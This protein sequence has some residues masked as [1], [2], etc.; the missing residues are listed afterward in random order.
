MVTVSAKDVGTDQETVRRQVM[1]IRDRK[2]VPE[3]RDPVLRVARCLCTDVFPR[4]ALRTEIRK[5]SL[6]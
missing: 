2:H 4:E 5:I 6:L 3:R 1:V